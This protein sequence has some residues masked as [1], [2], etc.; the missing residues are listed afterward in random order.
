MAQFCA[1]SCTS[2]TQNQQ[3]NQT[4]LHLKSDLVWSYLYDQPKINNLQSLTNNM[5]HIHIYTPSIS[6]TSHQNITLQKLL[7]ITSYHQ[8]QHLY[9]SITSTSVNYQRW[10]LKSSRATAMAPRSLAATSF[11]ERNQSNS[12]NN[13][14]SRKAFFLYKTSRSSVTTQLSDSFGSFRRKRRNTPSNKSNK[15]CRMPLK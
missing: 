5:S 8:T 11:A 15:S 6:Y 9:Q 1:F 2:R 10:H 4:K 7:A 3:Q 14:L 13:F 12:L